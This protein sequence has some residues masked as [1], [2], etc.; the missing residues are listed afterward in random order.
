MRLTS[1]TRVWCVHE[2]GV[3]PILS[4]ELSFLQS[5]LVIHRITLSSS[6][7][8]HRKYSSASCLRLV[9]NMKHSMHDD[10]EN[11]IVQVPFSKTDELLR[12]DT[13]LPGH[14]WIPLDDQ[15][16]MRECLVTELSTERLKRIY[17]ILFLASKRRNISPLHHQ[18][19]KGRR[20]IITE[21]PDLHLLWHYDRIFIKPIP[22]Y[23]FS[24]DFWADHIQ[25]AQDQD[26][27]C[28]GLEARGFL[29]THARLIVHES[30]FRLA[31]ELN[32]VPGHI[33]WEA[34]C[35]FIQG[36]RS[37][38]DREVAPRY[39]YGEI[40]LTRINFWTTVM[41]GMSY[42]SMPRNYSSFIAHFGPVYLFIF[43]AVTVLLTA[44]QTGLQGQ[45][46]EVYGD[47]SAGFVRFALGLTLAALGL[48]PLISIG[49]QLRALFRF[50]RYYQELS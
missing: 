41:Q 8:N 14:P 2:P 22:A 12:I 21:R 5:Q 31:Q 32:L 16:A 27:G 19:V 6:H 40:R 35:R 4:P 18:A 20:I 17:K 37:L 42:F 9:A 49:L 45:P 34:W 48:L 29:R 36:F 47:F 38:R 24:H 11:T 33:G 44:L 13:T 46:R 3:K 39:H 10:L 30:D 25:Q 50:F 28:L 43:G 7:P 15:A 26:G 23:C 1:Q